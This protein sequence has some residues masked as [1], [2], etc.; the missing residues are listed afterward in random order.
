MSLTEGAI[1][2]IQKPVRD[3][4][5][6]TKAVQIV[7]LPDPRKKLLVQSGQHEEIA[8][9]PPFRNHTVG[10][11]VD[12]I[13]YADGKTK[14]VVWH[15]PESVVLILDDDDRRDCAVFPLVLSDAWEKLKKL[16]GQL[17]PL[18]QK[19]FI[20]LLR[21]V[22]GASAATITV[23][24]KLSFQTQINGG[25]E[26]QKSRESLGNSI[27]AEVQ[28]TADLPE[29]LIVSVPI[30]QNAGERQVY[31]VR[32]LLEYDGQAQ[33]ILVTPDQ[34]LLAELEEAHQADIRSRLTAGLV[35]DEEHPAIPVYFGQP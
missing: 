4:E 31:S 29:E 20:R 2:A 7:D 9:P 15:S 1:L 6:L 30:Y 14:A 21:F 19:D 24:R 5:Q 3:A 8:V 33:R 22:L 23:F 35:D 32:L 11:L 34:G 10:S 16:D 18:T 26:I 25:G 13:S 28:G 17:T 12:L 27:A